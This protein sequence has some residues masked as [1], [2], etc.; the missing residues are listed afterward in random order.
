MATPLARHAGG[1]QSRKGLKLGTEAKDSLGREL[2]SGVLRDVANPWLWC[3]E[4]QAC[5]AGY[6][7]FSLHLLKM[8]EFLF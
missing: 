7:Q 2:G 1:A 8:E 5:P 4:G 6:H 3:N